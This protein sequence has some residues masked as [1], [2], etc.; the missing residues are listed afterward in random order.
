[1]SE[2]NY[3]RIKEILARRRKKASMLAEYMQVEPRTVSQWNTNSNQPSI[4]NLYKIAE[5]LDVEASELLTPKSEL[6]LIIK[7]NKKKK[8]N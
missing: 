3:N 5:F 2:F 8:N 6:R 7:E 4:D 1:M